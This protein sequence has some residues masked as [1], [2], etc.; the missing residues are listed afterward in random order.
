MKNTSDEFTHSFGRLLNRLNLKLRPK[1]ILIFLLV[2]VIPIILLTVIAFTQITSLGHILR[3]LAVADATKALNN[4][5][6]ESI[7]RLTTDT[8]AAV[9]KFLYQRDDDIRLLAE[10]VSKA[11]TADD[12]NETIR[13]FADGKTGRIM[14][15]RDWVIAADGMSWVEKEP[16]TYSDLVNVSSNREN[17]DELFGSSFN[18]RTPDYFMQFNEYVPLYDEVTYIDLNGNEIYKYVTPNS[19]KKNY[20]LNTDKANIS[21]KRNTYIKAENYFTELK[22][23]KPG[24]IYVSDVIGAYVG[25]N[26][27]GMYTPGV[28]MNVPATHP[29]Y[30]LLQE[31]ASLPKEEF[32]EVA[33]KQAYAGKENPVG[34]RFE[35]IVRW[36]TPVTGADGAVVGYLTMALNHD[37]IME[38]VD[39]ITPMSERY[40]ELPSAY[41]GNYA[42]IWDYQ[43]RNICH[44]RH[45]SIV[46]F[47]PVT[48]EP[49]VPWL[50]GTLSYERDYVNGGFLKDGDN[51]NIPILVNGTAVLAQDTP[52]YQWYSNGGA[53]WLA[54]NPSWDN[55][56]DE[57]AGVSWGSYFEEYGKDREILPRFGERILRDETG[58]PVTGP[59]GTY[60]L[61]YQSRDKTPAAALTKAGFVGLDGRYLNNAPQCTGWMNLTENGGSGSFYILWSDL[62]KPT[63]AGAIPYYTGHY[64]PEYQNGSKRGFAFV[65]IGAGIEG[66]TAPAREMGVTLTNA[67]DSNMADDMKKLIVTSFILFGIVIT[68]ALLLSSYLTD[69]INL[70]LNGIARFRAGER[71]FRIHAD[72]KDEFGVLA[73]SLDE[74]S[75]SLVDSVK[76]PLSIIDMNHRIIYMNDTAVRVLG[77]TLYEVAGGLYS[78]ISLYP[79][80]SKYDPVVA[81]HEGRDA[82]VMYDVDSGHYF[83]GTANYLLDQDGGKIGYIIVTN[84]ITEIEVARQKAEQANQAKSVFLANMSHEIRT[85]MNAIIG[86]ASIGASAPVL[87]KKDYAIQKIQDASKQLLAIINDVLDM[88]KIEA[89]KF[90]L[91]VEEFVFEKMV[92]RVIDVISFRADEK[93]QSLTVNID[94]SIPWMLVGD[95]QR[96]AQV[97]TNLLTNAVK[98]THEGGSIYFEATLQSEENGI[99]TLMVSIRDNGIGISAEQI[100]R[101][102][103]AFEQAEAS[104]TRKYGGTGLGL[105]IS[106]SI[107]EMMD[108]KIWVESE[109]GKGSKF[110]FT[111]CLARGK[112]DLSGII[113]PGIDLENARILAVDDELPVLTFFMETADRMGFNCDIASGGLE[114]LSLIEQ[115]GFYD[116]Y[117]V[118]WDMPDMDGLELARKI[119]DNGRENRIIIMIPINKW[120]TIHD[121]AL[122]TGITRSITKPLF[123]TAI[124]NHINDCL[125]VT[126]EA[127]EDEEAGEDFTGYRILLAED[128]DINREIVI[129]VLEPTGLVI[130]CALNGAQAVDMFIAEP[131]RYDMIFMD[132]QMPEMDGY[133]AT[134]RIRASAVPRAGEIPIVAMTANVFKE[135]I[136]KCLEAGMNDHMGKPLDFDV[137][138]TMLRTYL[139]RRN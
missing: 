88:S 37:H 102:F 92:A 29:N 2:K 99:C 137:V 53:E 117:F 129:A 15:Q 65:T 17:N 72:I 93:Q 107:I 68:M 128:V 5:A 131:E 1:L 41:E 26:Y 16:H 113:H 66:F 24:E 69:N 8:A 139:H 45:H 84:D 90:S 4:S 110:S 38:F 104:T 85:P 126:I 50:E 18:Y 120:D 124:A 98:F 87:E 34:Q 25:T 97:I 10:L 132:L 80:N 100:S 79:A 40:T 27:I 136:E 77:R 63:T 101:L 86:M 56:S 60:I 19:T 112:A 108:G 125:S 12:I 109:V 81:L 73:N 3:E 106:K 122:E 61:D 30:E 83:R 44:P 74:M 46:G 33:K 95:D 111:V 22:K 118:D 115:N 35:G 11:N 119:N 55:L 23:L 54:A 39:Y 62:Y 103:S 67:I 9:S 130:D 70:M 75:D 52:F 6:R 51:K 57:P 121:S 32:I 127:E 78:D 48:G 96:F 43:C 49:Q 28:L 133:T 134:E 21:D 105:V 82:E 123:M 47:N 13:V 31:I 7:E 71:Q 135:D 138:M 20:P 36:A 76:E 114:A 89:N 14:R 59:N 58:K 94:P 91:S 42:F 116:M 64:A